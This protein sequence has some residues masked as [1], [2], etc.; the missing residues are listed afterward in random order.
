[1]TTLSV[2]LWFCLSF[3]GYYES[4]SSTRP[5][6]GSKLTN[7]WHLHLLISTSD[8]RRPS[9]P[10]IY[11]S[12][13]RLCIHQS[14]DIWGGTNVSGWRGYVPSFY[15]SQTVESWN[16]NLDIHRR[17]V[18][19]RVSSFNNSFSPALL[20]THSPDQP[21]ATT[22][23]DLAASSDAQSKFFKSLVNFMSTYGFD[24]ID[25]DWYD[26]T[27]VEESSTD[28]DQGIPSRAWAIWQTSRF[29]QLRLIPK[30]SEECARIGRA[31]LW[32]D[33]YSSIVILVHAEFWHGRHI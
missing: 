19:E 9:V 17:L 33:H 2:V 3:E 18:N 15:R 11:P 8:A 32:V 16:A 4:W 29:S 5:C 24:G 1:M 23:S 21:T 31:Q 27:D 22:F 26:R 6:G 10:S 13:F 14:E 20:I 12:Q 28:K 30:E 7:S 25:M